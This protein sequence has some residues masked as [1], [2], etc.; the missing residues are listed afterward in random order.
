VRSS[1]FQKEPYILSIV[2]RVLNSEAILTKKWAPSKCSGWAEVEDL[3]RIYEKVKLV[4]PIGAWSAG[5]KFDARVFHVENLTT[6]FM[7]GDVVL[8]TVDLAMP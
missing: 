7:N 1:I 4:K 8:L 3:E 6:A 2:N 5:S